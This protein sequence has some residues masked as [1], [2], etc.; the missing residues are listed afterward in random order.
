LQPTTDSDNLGALSRRDQ[1]WYRA[2]VGEPIGDRLLPLVDKLLSIESDFHAKNLAR[3]RIY[4]GTWLT[5]GKY[6]RNGQRQ[7][8]TGALAALTKM[9]VNVARLN[10]TKAVC[11]TFS[12]RLSK[13]R[14]MPSFVTDDSDWDL[15]SKAKKYRSFIVGQ[16]LETE[17]DD[18]SARAL[19]DGT[20]LGFGYTY[21]DESD[22]AILA[23]RVHHNDILFDRR[24][25]KYGKPQQAFRIQRV[26]R[27][28]LAELYE[29]ESDYIINE[30]PP[31]RMR[32]S[33]QYIDDGPTISDLDD[34]VDVWTAWHLP[35]TSDSENGRKAI[36]C[37]NRTLANE[38]W[39]EPRFPWTMFQLSDPDEGMYPSGFVDDLIEMQYRVNCIIRDIQ[40]N[41]M[42]TGRGH[43]LTHESNR[44]PVEMLNAMQ[45][46][47]MVYSGTQATA[48]VWTAPQPYNPAQMSA[49]DKFV[50]L[51]FNISGV[52]KANAESRSALGAGASG[53][54]LD[55][56]YD[57]DSDRFRGPQRK[58]ARYRLHG[59]QGY[60]DASKRVARR[61]DD[62]KGK[63]RSWVA[64][65]WKGRDA[66]QKLDYAA[67]ELKE[68]TYRLA[69]E[70]VGFIPDTRAGKLSVV[71]QLAKAGVIPQWMVPML[72]D[73]PDLQEANRIILA[74]IKNALRKMDILVDVD[75]PAPMPEQYNDL[76]I[77]LK[78]S[79]AFY[80]WI[81][82]ENAPQEVQDRFLD[83]I[84]NVVEAI[85][86]YQPPAPPAPPM[87]PAE[88]PMPGGIPMMPQGPVPQPMT[89]GA[90]PMPPGM[91]S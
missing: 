12:S 40:L 47:E 65:T 5:P 41:L 15:K 85:K 10:V 44:L 8:F 4:R 89:I 76:D 53:I 59:A 88:Q 64:T 21:I 81:Q 45:P 37:G 3:Q 29:D 73:E 90:P 36:I 51:M 48:P 14:P 20:R 75:K 67:V 69:I 50:D 18:L 78:I 22:D 6:G 17:F 35:S 86:Q 33:D 84:A 31:S 11:D 1:I 91:A 87:A 25:C 61:R 54:A 27:D 26:A 42:V 34:Y 66:I 23:E 57:I 19:E 32:Q 83:Y 28:Y 63:K 46:F 56:Q 80:N 60:L 30:A 49:L 62:G 52:S 58:Y 79:K 77:E 71:E 55:T 24:E 2:K 7:P 16:M 43:Y 68:G 72:F 39:W 74:P 13:D 82:C 38:R 9:G 70:A